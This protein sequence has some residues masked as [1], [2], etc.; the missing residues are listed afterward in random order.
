[1]K[2][3]DIINKIS[4]GEE[5]KDFTVDDSDKIFGVINGILVDKSNKKFVSW[6]VTDEWLNCKVTFV[7]NEKENEDLDEYIEDYV[8]EIIKKI[9]F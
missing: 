1:M 3:I 5:I 2:V 9:L 4:K 6:K 7:S 8:H